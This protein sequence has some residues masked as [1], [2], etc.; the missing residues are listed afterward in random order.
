MGKGKLSGE[1]WRKGKENMR[2]GEGERRVK[3]NE[4]GRKE[5]K[6]E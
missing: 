3:K 4:G 1:R 2:Y 6:E 5:G